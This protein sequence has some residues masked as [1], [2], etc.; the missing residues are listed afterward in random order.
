MTIL[1]VQLLIDITHP[2]DTASDLELTDDELSDS[3]SDS[4]TETDTSSFRPFSRSSSRSSFSLHSSTFEPTSSSLHG[5]SDAAAEQEFRTELA[6]SVK[7]AFEENHSLDNAAVELK[8]LRMASNGKLRTVRE[9]VVEAVVEKIA[10]VEGDAQAQKKE[11]A[12]VVDRWGE[13]IDKIGGID[14]EETIEILQVSQIF[15][16]L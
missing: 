16:V 6:Q 15:A 2:G 3:D 8:T 7:R 4:D 13:L 1:R 10:I 11:I 9:V 14:H 5:L 12:Q